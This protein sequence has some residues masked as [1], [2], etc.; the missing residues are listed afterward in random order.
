MTD[1]FYDGS[2]TN[3][4]WLILSLGVLTNTLVMAVQSMCMP[5]LFKAISAD[6]SLNLVQV[7][8]VWGIV[9]LPGI[10]TSLFGGAAADR[11]G[12]KRVL[13]V[14]CFLTGLAGALR[15]L[16][17]D[18]P[19]LLGAMFLFGMIS[20]FIPMVVLKAC[21]LW[22]P[23]QQMGLA[24][25]VLSIGMAAGFLIGSLISATLL[26]PL[27]GGWR[28]VLFF[29]GILAMLMSIPWLFTRP[30]PAF[31][32]Q[33]K[34]ELKPVSMK[35]SMAIVARLRNV[36]LFGLV[37]FGINGCVQGAIGYLPLYLNGLGWSETAAASASAVFYTTSLIFTLPIALWSDR[38]GSRRKVSLA[39]G[40]LITSGI[41]LLAIVQGGWIWAAV[42]I[43]GMAGDGFMAVTLTS[44]M[45]TEG[46]GNTF[47]GAAL[48][49]VMVFSRLGILIAPSMGNSL[50]GISASLPFLL[51]S[52]M[53]GVGLVGLVI[54]QEERKLS[55]EKN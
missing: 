22:F 47:A 30:A 6:L 40:L 44:V 4:R 38:L 54:M 9:A 53:G 33:S 5:V 13:V 21:G 27:L 26:A 34:T 7:G 29:Y 41:G 32:N 25:G 15:G 43:A 48:G 28:N 46:V 51:W 52:I 20:T 2:K 17:N 42:F 31:S 35:Q 50:A 45:E 1:P 11:F 14:G 16:A 55:F 8:M 3:Y 18:F 19:S 39:A 37:F 24:S 10:A 23:R 12:P 36:W 49:L